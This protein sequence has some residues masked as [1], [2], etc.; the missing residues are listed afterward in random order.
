MWSDGKGRGRRRKEEK[1][2][3][4]KREKVIKKNEKRR[5]KTRIFVGAVL[6][7]YKE[8][9]SLSLC[10]SLSDIYMVLSKGV[11]FKDVGE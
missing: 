2:R 5:K 11:I 6:F 8:K 10:F 1:K 7:F 4:K 9:I 3:K